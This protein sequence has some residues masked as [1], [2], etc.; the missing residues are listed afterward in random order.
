MHYGSYLFSLG[1]SFLMILH[2][3]ATLILRRSLFLWLPHSLPGVS[4][5]HNVAGNGLFF[6]LK[7]IVSRIKDTKQTEA[8]VLAQNTHK[9]NPSHKCTWGLEQ[10]NI[11]HAGKQEGINLSEESVNLWFWMGL[12]ICHVRIDENV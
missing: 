12:F 1:A 6:S 7:V 11:V 3:L 9:K 5:L 8:D 10:T 2:F 4:A